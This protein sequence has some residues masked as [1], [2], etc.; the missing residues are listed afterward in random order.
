[1]T[2]TWAKELARYGIRVNAIAPGFIETGMVARVPEK[3]LERLKK[4]IPVGRLGKPADVAN[5]YLF[6]ASDEADYINGT[7]LHVDGGI[8]M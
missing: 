8:V 1:M 3:V 4:Q 2:R 5:A 7:V 6:L